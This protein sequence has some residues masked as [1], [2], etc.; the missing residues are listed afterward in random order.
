MSVRLERLKAVIKE[1]AAQLILH[2]LSDPRIGF[3]T[4]TRVD[5]TNDLSFC[6]IHV[7]VLG[8]DSQK[9][10]TLRGLKDARGLI[11]K[12][13][14]ARLKTRTTPH[15]EIELDESVERAFRV[16]D[17]IKEARASDPDGGKST[18]EL[19]TPGTKSRDEDDE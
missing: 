8:D 11:Q 14:A 6:T 16:M 4:V 5:L 17:K 13:V 12:C 1:E 9:N 7:S 10:K 18:E 3:C 15:I 2:D 19:P